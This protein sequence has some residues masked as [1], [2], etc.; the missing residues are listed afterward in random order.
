MNI[1]TFASMFIFSALTF[2]SCADKVPVV[3]YDGTFGEALSY[4][5]EFDKPLCVVLMDSI[6]RISKE[7]HGIAQDLLD[8]L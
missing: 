7:M 8:S 4:A 2:T 6:W 3:R 5:Q 1:K